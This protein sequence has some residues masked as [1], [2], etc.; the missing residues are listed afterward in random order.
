MLLDP[1]QFCRNRFDLVQHRMEEALKRENDLAMSLGN[2]QVGVVV[3][4]ATVC[5]VV[6]VS[7]FLGNAVLCC[8]LYKTS[9]FR[10]P[11]NYY[12]MCLAVTDMLVAV[13]CIP[14]FVGVLIK[15]KWILSAPFCQV[16]GSFIFLLVNA[17]LFTM[18]L[19]A[20]NRYFKMTKSGKIYRRIY[21]K[22]S[23]LLSI[24]L[25]WAV[26]LTLV[27]AVFSFGSQVFH[28][29]PGKFLCFLD[30]THS[31]G[32]RVYSLVAYAVVSSVVFPVMIICYVQVYRKVRAHF[33]ENAISGH[34]RQASRSFVNEAKITKMLFVT[35]V[36][37]LVCWTPAIIT[38]IF[39]AF[40]GQYSLPRQ[41]YFWQIIIFASSSA[42]NPIIYGFMRQ[43]IRTAYKEVLTCKRRDSLTRE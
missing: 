23:I 42:V 18:A 4:E 34:A 9:G 20:V 19:I 13:L 38:D 11:Q 43:E 1:R 15:G 28:F 36:A 24:L 25:A 16:Q 7:A 12:I 30:M 26:S 3:F 37:F 40:Y 32:V 35:L 39:E 10:A 41:V 14:F 5:V 2:R 17:S 8:S 21:T 33:V 6:G 27:L 31:Q 22:R 29:H